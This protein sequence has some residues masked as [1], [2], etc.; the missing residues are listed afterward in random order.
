MAKEL[1][2]LSESILEKLMG[3]ELDLIEK[4]GLNGLLA[5][6][7][8]MQPQLVWSVGVYNDDSRK[9]NYVAVEDLANHIAYNLS[10]RPG[11]AFFVNLHCLNQG[12]LGAK[13][14]DEWKERLRRE[15]IPEMKRHTVPYQ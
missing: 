13:R 14:A 2:G 9:Q 6:I 4:H 5:E 3:R 15:G 1:T 12:Y 8:E 10:Y 7:S 11:R